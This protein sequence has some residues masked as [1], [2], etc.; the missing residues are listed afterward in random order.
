MNEVALKPQTFH[1][2]VLTAGALALFASLFTIT[3]ARAET[4]FQLVND[5]QATDYVLVDA[6]EVTVEF[7]GSDYTPRCL[8]VRS[9]TRV[10]LPGSAKHPL[11]G[12]ED[13]AGVPN[14]FRA[15]QARSLSVTETLVAE[16][17]YSYHCTNHK[18]MTAAIRVLAP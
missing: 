13:V 10:T 9:G 14:P 18:N 8:S 4:P 7:Q 11:Q 1:P 16:G 3:S 5:C 6:P 12:L 15:P 2:S 17:F